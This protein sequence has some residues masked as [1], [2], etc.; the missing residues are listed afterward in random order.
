MRTFIDIET[1]V[2]VTG[3][4]AKWRLKRNLAMGAEYD[5]RLRYK[6]I[7]EPLPDGTYPTMGIRNK[8]GKMR[9]MKRSLTYSLRQMRIQLRELR[10]AIK[11]LK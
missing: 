1:G 5:G 9:R 3:D 7:V 8:Y 10:K 4:Y 11:E 6:D 2:V